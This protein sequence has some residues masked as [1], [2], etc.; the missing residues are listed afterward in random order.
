[1]YY[2]YMLRCENDSIYTGIT[3][4]V[5]RRMQ[6]HFSRDKKCAKYTKCHKPKKLESVWESENKVLAS[7][8]E[9]RIKA[10]TKKQKEELI[11]N[12]DLEKYLAD[13]IE[14]E[15]YKRICEVHNFTKMGNSVII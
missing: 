4:D 5:E 7:K 2:T 3:T 12:K 15:K 11:K 9:Y 14:C 8:L 10:L 1:M 6:E 13:K